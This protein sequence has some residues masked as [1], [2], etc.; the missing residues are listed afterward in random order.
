MS[1]TLQKT[2]PSYLY[3]Q[4]ADD[5]DLQAFVAAYNDETQKYVD[6]FNGLNL[7]VYTQLSGSLLDWVGAG[8]Y[9]YPRPTLPGTAPSSVGPINTYGPNYAVPL[10]GQITTAGTTYA[11]TDDLY[12]RLLTW[13]F[14]KGDGKAF[15]IRW[16][17]RRVMRFLIG[18]NGTAPNIEQTYQIGVTF[19]S[20]NVVN[21]SI[22]TYPLAT[23]FQS[24]IASGAA[25]TP[26]QYTFTVSVSGAVIYP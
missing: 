2:I 12:Q 3:Q 8:V 10:N 9:G 13:H 4:Y 24:A 1:G 22:P 11:T 20:G 17:K 14:Y 5:D 7:P 25:E 21:I 15:S 26:F 23:A 16:L 19:T 6:T 18:A